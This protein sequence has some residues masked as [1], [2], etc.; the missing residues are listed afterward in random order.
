MAVSTG[1]LPQGE[2]KDS[3]A[4]VELFTDAAIAPDDWR[5][6]FH[7]ENAPYDADGKLIGPAI[8]GARRVE[9]RFGDIKSDPEVVALVAAIKVKGYAWRTADIAA[10]EAAKAAAQTPPTA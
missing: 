9:R 5:V 8:F 6:V 1:P 10:E 2:F 7:F 4:R 3:I